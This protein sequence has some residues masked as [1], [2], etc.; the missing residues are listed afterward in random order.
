VQSPH[1][2]M[3]E[4]RPPYVCAMTEAT[5]EEFNQDTIDDEPPF[6]VVDETADLDEDDLVYILMDLKKKMGGT[7]SYALPGV[8]KIRDDHSKVLKLFQ[9]RLW[10]DEGT[11]E[12]PSS[13]E[14][15]IKENTKLR[16]GGSAPGH[17]EKPSEGEME[18]TIGEIYDDIENAIE[19][20]T[21]LVCEGN[22]T[23]R[24][25]IYLEYSSKTLNSAHKWDLLKGILMRMAK[26][27]GAKEYKR[28]APKDPARPTQAE[29]KTF[30]TNYIEPALAD[31]L[32]NITD[33]AKMNTARN[34]LTA[35]RA[36]TIVKHVRSIMDMV[37]EGPEGTGSDGGKKEK[38]K[39]EKGGISNT[40]LQKSLIATNEQVQALGR[41]V[42]V[43]SQQLRL[44][45]TATEA[46]PKADGRIAKILKVPG[47]GN[48]G[49]TIMDACKTKVENPEA[50]L[51]LGATSCRLMAAKA[52]KEVALQAFRFYKQDKDDFESKYGEYEEFIRT[53]MVNDPKELMNPETWAKFFHFYCYTKAHPQIEFRIKQVVGKDGT[54]KIQTESTKTE[55]GPQPEKVC[56]I[57]LK[58]GNHFDLI[59]VGDDDV[60]EYFFSPNETKQAEILMDALLLA[61]P[62]QAKEFQ[63]D[64]D[65]KE[66][67]QVLDAALNLGASPEKE[68]LFTLVESKNERKKKKQ[69]TTLAKEKANKEEAE[70]KS[71]EKLAI[72]V[73]K[74][75]VKLNGGTARVPR[76]PR[77]VSFSEEEVPSKQAQREHMGIPTDYKP[78]AVVFGTGSKKKLR[79]MIKLAAP[80]KA[81]LIKSMRQIET[82]TPRTI[83][84]C[85]AGDLAA[86]MEMIPVL[87]K[88]RIRC[89]EYKEQGQRRHDTP[90]TNA[91]PKA[92]Q[93]DVGLRETSTNAGICHYSTS[94]QSC[95]YGMKGVCKFVCTNQ[96]S[97]VQRRQPSGWRR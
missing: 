51:D 76:P 14:I 92:Q 53:L 28:L 31:L 35:L 77:K 63:Q 46:P 19:V 27:M 74:E 12:E 57:K 70:K 3:C 72:A 97:S 86:A 84:Y 54:R 56:F 18:G 4:P 20:S 6:P 33:E 45:S 60:S 73:A 25:Y 64:M 88:D 24:T 75:V 2:C 30:R 8:V 39:H 79:D 26:E 96:N 82:G 15:E 13:F 61:T 10:A 55:G 91:V 41:Q 48:C 89:Y 37:V 65:E 59:A 21:D 44:S 11:F 90:N 71:T 9:S 85:E 50:K 17:G 29:G 80:E 5:M 62:Q 87:E 81:D 66:L 47:D 42:L 93:A 22:S 23:L 95:P 69:E 36:P 32:S 58:N 83:L 78:F 67:S 68:E 7:T 52:R 49:F 94:G 40:D 16:I 38:K 1:R 43:L 34:E